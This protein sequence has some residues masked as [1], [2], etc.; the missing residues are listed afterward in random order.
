MRRRTRK[1]IL[2]NEYA[3]NFFLLPRLNCFSQSKGAFIKFNN[4]YGLERRINAF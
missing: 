2:Q 4:S 3:N 1:L